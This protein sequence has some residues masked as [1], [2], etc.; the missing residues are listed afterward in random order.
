MKTRRY[1]SMNHSLNSRIYNKNSVVKNRMIKLLFKTSVNRTY[2][3]TDSPN[4]QF[5]YSSIENKS[6]IFPRLD[7][8]NI[9]DL[10]LQSTKNNPYLFVHHHLNRYQTHSRH[11]FPSASIGNIKIVT[12]MNDRT[13]SFFPSLWNISNI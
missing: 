13:A 10:S 1:Q 7:C 6:G 3:Q 9:K 11:S 2:D 4:T 8:A 5:I 12:K